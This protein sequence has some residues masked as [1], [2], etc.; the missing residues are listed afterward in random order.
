MCKISNVMKT[1]IVIK[2][3]N[4]KNMTRVSAE[5]FLAMEGLS[6]LPSLNLICQKLLK[7]G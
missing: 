1:I 6:N 4:K 7:T 5:K 3:E 2:R